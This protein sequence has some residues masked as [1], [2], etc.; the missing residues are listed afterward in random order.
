MPPKRPSE[1]GYG[2]RQTDTESAKRARMDEGGKDSSGAGNVS[3]IQA[4]IEAAKALAASRMAAL[5]ASR[6]AT[7]SQ[8]SRPAPT[9]SA[10]P[11]AHVG[12]SSSSGNATSIADIQRQLEEAKRK[13]GQYNKGQSGGSASQV[14]QQR[15][16]GK[17]N[18]SGLHPLLMDSADKGKSLAT[19]KTAQIASSS[20]KPLSVAVENPYLARDEGEGDDAGR[21]RSRRRA[22][23][24]NAPGRHIRAAEDA[25]REAQM[26]ALKRRIEE[27]A[28]K[29]GLEELSAEERALRRPKPPGIEWWDQQFLPDQDTYDAFESKALLDGKAT[30]I[31]IYVQHP[32]P[33]PAPSDRVK[34]EA[35]GVMLTKQEQKKMRRLR[36]RA[37]Q[38]DKQDQIK[39]GLLPPDPPKV[40]LGNLMRVLTSE[41]VADPTKIEARVR[42]DVAARREKHELDN[43][44]RMLTAEQRKA[45]DDEQKE[46]DLAKGIYT[47]VFK[48]KHLI[49]PSHKFKVRKNAQQLGLTGL[50]LFGLDFALVLVEGGHKGIKAYRHLL[51]NRIKWDDPGRPRADGVADLFADVEGGGPYDGMDT[52]HGGGGGGAN[53]GDGQDVLGQIDW[54]QNY[55]KL[56]F[57]GPVRDRHFSNG[58]RARQCEADIDAKQILGPKLASYWDLAKRE[59]KA[60]AEDED[61]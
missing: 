17:G 48:V 51:L 26:E 21:M 5:M 53:D 22:L 18:P 8:P 20:R 14:S 38:E 1:G 7:T 42:R 49:S 23:V 31:D 41:A 45:K 11:V 61:V 15:V 60:L 12:G 19:P 4:Q 32:I 39:M 10:R 52:P 56:L 29:A 46:K 24:F 2:D 47:L 59:S 37:E 34:V 3:S 33:I 30:P 40:K 44:E 50:A 25:R 54:T 36:R 58:F 13:M 16:D 27:Q 55:C 28:R 35:K 9:Q 57:E 6:N 43:M